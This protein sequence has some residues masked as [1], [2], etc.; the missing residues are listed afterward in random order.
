[1]LSRVARDYELLFRGFYSELRCET[2]AVPLAFARLRN[3]TPF[4]RQSRSTFRGLFV[5]QVFLLL[6][7][8][9]VVC[10]RRHHDELSF[11]YFRLDYNEFYATHSSSLLTAE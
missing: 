6:T 8:S 4:F 2:A 5:R 9:A 1:M 7:L 3:L 11:L 10:W